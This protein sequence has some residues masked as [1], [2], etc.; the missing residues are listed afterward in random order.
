MAH[1]IVTSLEKDLAI[2]FQ[3]EGSTWDRDTMQKHV[4]DRAAL[5]R[6]ENLLLDAGDRLLKGGDAP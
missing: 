2:H 3:M 6:V 1:D 5:L 4:N